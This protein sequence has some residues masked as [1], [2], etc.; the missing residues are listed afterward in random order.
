MSTED[1]IDEVTMLPV[2]E[3]LRIVDA[4]LKSMNTP[5]PEVDKAWANAAQR[6]LEELDSG[7]VEAIPGEVVIEQVRTRFNHP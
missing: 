4:L 3:R 2:E 7:K 6:R 5:D 1:L